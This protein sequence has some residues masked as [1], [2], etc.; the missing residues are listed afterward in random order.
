MRLSSG[1][2]LNVRPADV[3][4]KLCETEAVIATGKKFK[5]THLYRVEIYGN[6]KD[7]RIVALN[8]K[9]AE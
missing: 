7:G 8:D 6:D 1:S 5:V 2:K 9:T 3:F 4:E